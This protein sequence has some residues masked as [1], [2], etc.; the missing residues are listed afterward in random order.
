MANPAWVKEMKHLK[1]NLV[2][3]RTL[4][5]QMK[6]RGVFKQTWHLFDA[7]NQVVGR[8][9]SKLATLLMGKHRPTYEKYLDEG[10][11]CVVV[12]CEKIILSG[13]RMYNKL[14]RSHSGY[15]GGLKEIPAF[16]MMEKK[17]HYILEHAVRGMIPKNKLREGRMARL[18]IHKGPDHPYKD[19]F[20]NIEIPHKPMLPVMPP[21]MMRYYKML[22]KRAIREARLADPAEILRTETREKKKQ[23]LIRESLNLGTQSKASAAS[24]KPAPAKK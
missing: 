5:K 14:Y 12:N 13:N 4:K 10:D 24:E 15:P 16:M 6:T 21:G 2:G 23:E 18:I 19:K 8:M 11:V 22:S 7:T 20:G 1:K 17:P 9:A 3:T